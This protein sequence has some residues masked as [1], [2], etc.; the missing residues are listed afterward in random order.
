MTNT[1]LTSNQT[2][3]QTQFPI[4]ITPSHLTNFKQYLINNNKSPNTI[5][6]Y[7]LDINQY[8]SLFSTLSRENIQQYKHTLQ[9]NNISVSTI[10]HKL[11]A[12]KQFNEYLI[13]TNT[14]QEKD[15]YIIKSDFLKQQDKGN[16]T[17]VSTKE[18]ETF[19]KRVKNKKVKA[20]RK[21][22]QQKT[23]NIAITHLIANTGIRRDE[24]CNIEL[25]NINLDEYELTIVA[26][27]GNKLRT[28]LLNDKAVEVIKDYL[29]DRSK[30]KY[31]D[32]PYLFLSERGNKL[33]RE[34]IDGIFKSYST[35]SCKVPPHQ[36]RHNYATTVAEEEILEIHELQNQL[37]HSSSK[38]TEI[39]LHPRKD[40]MKKKINKLCIG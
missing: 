29:I 24:C 23:R 4:T 36:L 18:V 2:Q 7:L 40:V 37:G 21:G 17:C 8:L 22:N 32:S 15:I 19:L 16:P 25:K 10:N 38:T 33:T 6:S 12:L 1:T 31:A 9:T 35:P 28:V 39:Y 27:K 20:K 13:S 14:L 34:T 26:G 3:Q 5:T 11:T 30:S